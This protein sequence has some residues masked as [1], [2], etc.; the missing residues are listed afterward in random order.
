M[1]IK[2]QALFLV[3]KSECLDRTSNNVVVMP[4][5]YDYFGIAIE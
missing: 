3:E 1:V 2:F 4:G 5:L